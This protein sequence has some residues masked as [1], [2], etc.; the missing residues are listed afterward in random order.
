MT[1]VGSKK[2]LVYDDV[3]LEASIRVYDKGIAQLDEY[4]RTPESFAE[5]QFQIRT[6]DLVIPTLQFSE[7]LRN[8][9]QHF[10]ECIQKGQKPLSDGWNGLRVVRVL[11]AAER[12]LSKDGALVAV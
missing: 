8:E 3:S 11:E 7:P 10:I 6:G 5:F 9:C 1:L 2:M 12:S 4:L